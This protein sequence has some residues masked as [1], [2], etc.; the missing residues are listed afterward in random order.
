VRNAL[1]YFGVAVVA[2]ALSAAMAALWA[3]S[4]FIGDY[5]HLGPIYLSF[6][7]GCCRVVNGEWFFV[8]PF[9][10]VGSPWVTYPIDKVGEY[11]I[12]SGASYVPLWLL[13][14]IFGL[15]GGWGL[16]RAQNSRPAAA[17]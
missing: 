16:L 2:F 17:V 14:A 15:I 5:I 8:P 10:V 11:R 3:R 9:P 1:A 13:V 12:G 6:A 7:R 4:Y